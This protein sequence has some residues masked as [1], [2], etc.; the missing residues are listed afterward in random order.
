[1]S[2]VPT[3]SLVRILESPVYLPMSPVAPTNGVNDSCV[4]ADDDDTR[5]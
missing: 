2:L 1:M 3:L 4:G 5:R